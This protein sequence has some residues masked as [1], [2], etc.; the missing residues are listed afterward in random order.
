MDTVQLI[1]LVGF[2]AFCLITLAIAVWRV[3]IYVLGHVLTPIAQRH[4]QFIDALEKGQASRDETHR[5]QAL[6]LQSMSAEL[7]E[8]T[9]LLKKIGAGTTAQTKIMVD[10]HEHHRG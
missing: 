5:T 7:R 9:G 4:I 1:Q 10:E 2:P 8:Q 6:A 3:M